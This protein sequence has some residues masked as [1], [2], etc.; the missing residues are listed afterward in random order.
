MTS[1]ADDADALDKP[2]L[3]PLEI[4]P[5]EAD[6][7]RMFV[8]RDPFGH[9][10]EM[11]T[12]PEAAV[13]LLQFF[14]GAHT[15]E[16]IKLEFFRKTFQA[17]PD[18][19]LNAMI[20]TLD[21]AMM[22]EGGRFGRTIAS[23][24]SGDTRPPSHAG[25]SYPDDAGALREAIAGYYLHETGP[26]RLPES[27]DGDADD[28]PDGPI[29]AIVAPHIDLR[30]GGPVFAHAY[31]ALS[32]APRPD[33]FVILGTGHAGLPRLFG[34]TK[35]RFETPLGPLATDGDFL[36][37]LGAR[38]GDGLF[39]AELE[40]KG[41]HVIEFQTVFLKNLYGEAPSRIAPI[42][43]SYSFEHLTLPEAAEERE[44]IERF[45]RALAET[46]AETP[47][48]VCLIASV[49]L[50]HIGPRYGDA[51]AVAPEALEDNAR[52]DAAMLERVAASDAAGF[53]DFIAREEDARH[54]CGFPCLHTMLGV[55]DGA[56]GET[57][58][59]DSCPVDDNESFVSYVSMVFR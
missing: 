28:A 48:R 45:G 16:N 22:L 51:V 12:V 30:S 27:P 50:A 15:R 3:R 20:E 35:K 58:K 1:P 9:T 55:L 59:Y 11:V 23:Y 42:L 39:E 6:G 44:T 40:H 43:C 33:L 8:L 14:D 41:E 25:L 34:A 19:E 18:A 37:R 10:G 53:L 13:W 56:R 21:R 2:R 36:D 52:R 57:L 4:I 32:R 47:G 26:G 17:L 46:I 31:H 7:R 24:L 38:F 54:I 5:A 29:R 49:D